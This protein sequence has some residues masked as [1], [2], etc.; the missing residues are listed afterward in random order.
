[1]TYVVEVDRGVRVRVVSTLGLL[2]QGYV[3]LDKLS[4]LLLILHLLRAGSGYDIVH[5]FF[6]LQINFDRKMLD[7]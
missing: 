7:F 4:D 5:L 6:L 1:M 2:E 3:L